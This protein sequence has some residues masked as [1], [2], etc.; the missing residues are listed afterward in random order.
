MDWNRFSVRVDGCSQ[1]G[2][3]CAACAHG[4][5][6]GAAGGGGGVHLSPVFDAPASPT[7]THAHMPPSPA[8]RCQCVSIDT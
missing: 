4:R 2:H 6:A 5:R 1:I 7:P 3:T 8:A